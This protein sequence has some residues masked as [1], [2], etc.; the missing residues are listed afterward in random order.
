MNS[1]SKLEG[2]YK[3]YVEN[4]LFNHD[5]V[6]VSQFIKDL[7][8]EKNEDF[9][10]F[11]EEDFKG[12]TNFDLNIDITHQ[13][14][15]ENTLILT[16]FTNLKGSLN[17]KNIFV[18]ELSYCGVFQLPDVSQ[19]MLEKQLKVECPKI[20]FPYVRRIISQMMIESGLP[21]VDIK[22]INFFDLYKKN[23]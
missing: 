4:L 9:L 23:K 22:N 5:I 20:I 19:D 17:D 14:R 2:N 16:L 3:E 15:D 12:K 18:M 13:E 10:Y 21:N 8:F 1:K 6:L 11:E 7:S